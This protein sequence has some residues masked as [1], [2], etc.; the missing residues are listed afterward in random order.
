MSA[1]AAGDGG[2][3]ASGQTGRGRPGSPANIRMTLAT[4][5]AI[6][7]ILLVTVTVAAVGWLGFRNT[8]QAVIPRVW[9]RSRPSHACSRPVWNPMLPALAAIWSAIAPLRPS[10][11]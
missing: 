1:P 5:L 9:N 8:T 10:T 6:A 3:S 11:V 2:A 4:R 7:M